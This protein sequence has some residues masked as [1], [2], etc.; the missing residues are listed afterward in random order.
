[1]EASG[2]QSN[3][4]KQHESVNLNSYSLKLNSLPNGV[5]NALRDL[6]ADN[7]GDIDVTELQQAVQAFQADKKRVKFLRKALAI[8]TI[9][10]II[11]GAALFG[12]VYAVVVLTKETDTGD[13]GVMYVA[14]TET[15]VRVGNAESTMQGSTMVTNDGRTIGTRQAPLQVRPYY[16]YILSLPR[17]ANNVKAPGTPRILLLYIARSSSA[18][19]GRP[20]GRWD[21][22]YSRQCPLSGRL[23]PMKRIHERNTIFQC[24]P[25]VHPSKRGVRRAE[26]AEDL[27]GEQ[28][29]SQPDRA[30][31][32]PHSSPGGGPGLTLHR[33]DHHSPRPHSCGWHHPRVSGPRGRGVRGSRLRR[34]QHLQV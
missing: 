2:L 7:D 22:S 20:P 6:D 9:M 26:G 5:A 12:L 14:G 27:G 25:L 24:Q 1:M 30:R 3:N 29:L 21:N 15:L 11:G 13:N 4:S 16:F 23:G 8:A 31:L 10:M 19:F 28:R 32:D 33:E 18:R 34:G 17:T